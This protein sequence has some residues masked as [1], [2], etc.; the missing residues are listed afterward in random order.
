[1]KAENNENKDINTI[2][3][4]KF[5]MNETSL[6]QS[7]GKRPPNYENNINNTK[8]QAGNEGVLKPINYNKQFS[9]NIR[10]QDIINSTIKINNNDLNINQ[11]K[12]NVQN[13]ITGM[14]DIS[15]EQSLSTSSTATYSIPSNSKPL[16]QMNS[17]PSFT[18]TGKKETA[19]LVFGMSSEITTPVTM[20]TLTSLSNPQLSIINNNNNNKNNNNNNS[21]L[22]ATTTTSSSSSTTTTNNNSNFSQNIN[23]HFITN[24]VT[25]T[26]PNS[27]ASFTNI[28]TTNQTYSNNIS[29]NDSNS[30]I[31]TT[32]SLSNSNLK[33]IINLPPSIPSPSDTFNNMTLINNA[34]SSDMINVDN[35]LLNYEYPSLNG[36]ILPDS[37]NKLANVIQN[38]APP[39]KIVESFFD[40]IIKDEIQPLYDSDMQVYLDYLITILQDQDLIKELNIFQNSE[41]FSKVINF[42]STLSQHTEQTQI[43]NFGLQSLNMINQT[44]SSK[45]STDEFDL[46]LDDPEL[47]NIGVDDYLIDLPNDNLL[48][49]NP[50]TEQ[51][52]TQQPISQQTITQQPLAQQAITQQ[53]LAQQA[54]TQQSLAQQA[55]TQQPLAQQAITQQS[56]AQQAITQQAIAQQTI[57]QQPG[58]LSQPVFN[59]C[60][61]IIDDI[62]DDN[63]LNDNGGVNRY[64]TVM[65]LNKPT[66]D[67]SL[68]GMLSPQGYVSGEEGQLMN[69]SPLFIDSS[70][71]SLPLTPPP[72]QVPYRT[73]VVTDNTLADAITYNNYST[74]LNYNTIN[75]FEIETMD[76]FNE[77]DKLQRGRYRIVRNDSDE[78]PT[79]QLVL[80]N[81][82]ENFTTDDLLNKYTSFTLNTTQSRNVRRNSNEDKNSSKIIPMKMVI[83]K[84]ESNLDRS[85]NYS[86]DRSNY[87]NSD[88]DYSCNNNNGK[89][90]SLTNSTSN[91]NNDN[92][93]HNQNKIQ[94]HHHTNN[95]TNHFTNSNITRNI[96]NSSNNNNNNNN[97]NYNN[98]SSNNNDN[99]RRPINNMVNNQKNESEL[100]QMQDK[101]KEMSLTNLSNNPKQ[102]KPYSENNDRKSMNNSNNSKTSNKSKTNSNINNKSVKKDNTTNNDNQNQNEKMEEHKMFLQRLMLLLRQTRIQIPNLILSPTLP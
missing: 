29:S 97:N 44:K 45:S 9:V 63:A 46:D 77:Y 91:K 56:L 55:I 101:F 23:N 36:M 32:Q 8:R 74:I 20:Q 66:V 87:F 48:L 43:N 28:N 81:N 96:N 50:I 59:P 21:T 67:G 27:M 85:I 47:M 34:N 57:T 14:N 78:Q 86:N 2:Q 13:C 22:Y 39:I 17:N 84:Q 40:S 79:V 80:N 75:P 98:N 3:Y 93:S 88:I 33:N 53:S 72:Q 24:S 4:R 51:P 16:L 5:G 69:K 65:N 10:N 26:I 68:M 6:K 61:E 18:F 31:N 94:N 25:N 30:N 62:I 70:K 92:Y 100:E 15:S 52:L 64:E 73:S 89:N 49:N 90:D 82:S 42:L 71:P 83:K 54:I 38:N 11:T 76:S 58:L 7:I 41:D 60:E 1:M 102:Q 99:T 35:Q 95:N 19:N 12:N 37:N